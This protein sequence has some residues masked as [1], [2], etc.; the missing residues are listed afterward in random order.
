MSKK[1]IN[2]HTMIIKDQAVTI[3]YRLWQ[4]ISIMLGYCLGA[5]MTISLT[6]YGDDYD[7]DFL[8]SKAAEI[9]KK[10]ENLTD[11]IIYE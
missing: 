9:A 2:E 4:E 6:D 5:F 7:F 11:K 3:N 10:I 8:K 1:K